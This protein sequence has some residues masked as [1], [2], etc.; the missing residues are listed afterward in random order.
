M[1]CRDL[2]PFGRGEPRVELLRRP[3]KQLEP[4][5]IGLEFAGDA[6]DLEGLGDETQI[7]IARAHV[8][9]ELRE[10]PERVLQPD[11]AADDAAAEH[12]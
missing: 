4:E 3:G 1:R 9:E 8:G 5:N 12:L 2:S 11:V 10:I 7:E 6:A